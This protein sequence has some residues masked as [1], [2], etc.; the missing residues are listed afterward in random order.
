MQV[1]FLCGKFGCRSFQLY[2]WFT[3]GLNLHKDVCVMLTL[4][5][6]C[7]KSHKVTTT[8]ADFELNCQ[9][10][11]L[12]SQFSSNRLD[13]DLFWAKMATFIWKLLSFKYITHIIKCCVAKW[14]G[15]QCYWPCKSC[16][17]IL[18]PSFKFERLL[19]GYI[20]KLKDR[21]L[22]NFLLSIS[23]PYN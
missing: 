11:Q 9:H 14:W 13:V 16:Q 18:R 20:S 4:L 5:P 8:M 2:W 21:L 17:N 12:A 10:C 23:Q 15:N 6:F 1:F 3:T 19:I 22:I 7:M